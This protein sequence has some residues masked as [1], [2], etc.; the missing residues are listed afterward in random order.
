[1]VENPCPPQNSD[2]Q[3]LPTPPVH[4]SLFEKKNCPAVMRRHASEQVQPHLSGTY[5]SE[6]VRYEPNK[7][8]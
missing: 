6:G 5:L 8:T 1:M 7:S 4:P 3:Y 2:N